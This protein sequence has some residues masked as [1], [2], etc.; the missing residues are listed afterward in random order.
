MLASLAA[1]LTCMLIFNTYPIGL[2]E[3]ICGSVATLLGATCCYYYR[4]NTAK[5][6]FWFVFFNALITPIYLPITAAITYNVPLLEFMALPAWGTTIVNYAYA[7]FFTGISEAIVIYGLGYPFARYT[8]KKIEKLQAEE[9]S[10][11]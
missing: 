5:A 11:N 1:N 8:Q 10:E 9:S 3:V 2:T 6:L 7:A 4:S